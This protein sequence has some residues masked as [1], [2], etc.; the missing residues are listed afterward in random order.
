MLGALIAHH[1]PSEE[2]KFPR[3]TPGLPHPRPFPAAQRVEKVFDRPI[4]SLVR[5]SIG[6]GSVLP[7]AVAKR[8]C[9]VG[10]QLSLRQQTAQIA[11]QHVPTAALSEE[12]IARR[13]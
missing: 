9:W 2:E 5:K 6:C 13:V 1:L 3:Y 11:R 12:G 7:D 10:L 8:G 4:R